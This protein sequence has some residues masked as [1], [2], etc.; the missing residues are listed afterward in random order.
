MHLTTF[1][2]STFS[3]PFCEEIF[4]Q[5]SKPLPRGGIDTILNNEL[6]SILQLWV[7]L[8]GLIKMQE[9]FCNITYFMTCEGA[10]LS[11][12]CK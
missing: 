9:T 12:W 11:K 6:Y 7:P 4:L 2:N 10:V 8:H 5:V 3:N 1:Y